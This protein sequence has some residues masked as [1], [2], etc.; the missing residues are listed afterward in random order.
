TAQG[1]AETR[2]KGYELG[3]DEFIPKPF[4]LRELLIRVKHVLQSHIGS[5]QEI[6]TK[7]ASIHFTDLSIRSND[8]RIDYPSATDMKILKYL[9]EQSPRP[10]SRDDIINY[11]WGVD[12]EL[13]HRTI[14]NAIVRLRKALGSEGESLIRSVRGIGYQW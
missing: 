6:R 10:V 4:H 13:S 2:L 11:V 9:I 7:N 8:G 12:K 1:D 5:S 3:A 14:D